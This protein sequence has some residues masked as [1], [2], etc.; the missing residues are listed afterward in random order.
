MDGLEDTDSDL[1][2]P[3]QG[4]GGRMR[5]KKGTEGGGGSVIHKKK[6]KKAKEG[7]EF[8]SH[9]P[10]VSERDSGTALA[11][12][13]QQTMGVMDGNQI[14]PPPPG[15]LPSLWYSRECV[16][17]VF[18]IEKIIGWKT[19][20]VVKLRFKEE[21]DDG[22][23]EIEGATS[24]H[25][26]HH[27]HLDHALAANYS[28]KVIVEH[29]T[30]LRKR[31][32]VSK[33]NPTHCP[34][35]FSY[36][37]K[38]ELARAAKTNETPN[39]KLVPI[40]EEDREEVLLIKWRGRSHLHC[41]W[42][43]K[44]DLEKFDPSNNT[45]RGKIKR[46]LQAQ[47]VAMG[48]DWKK[49][50]EEGRASAIHGH[51]HAPPLPGDA[52][53]AAIA[54]TAKGEED[55]DKRAPVE[56]EEFFPPE[57]VEVERVLACDE[58]DVSPK[59]LAKQRALNRRAESEALLKREAEEA[60]VERRG[61]ATEAN[62]SN[63]NAIKPVAID[64]S[65][66]AASDGKTVD[67]EE[68]APW[69]PEDNV[70]YV[71][72]WK[73]MQYSEITWEY[74][75]DLKRDFVDEVEDFWYRQKAPP[76]E[77]AKMISC[78]PHP[79]MKEFKKLT[80]SPVFGISRRVRP[81]ADL[82]DGKLTGEEEDDKEEEG[83]TSLKLRNYQLEGVNWL[84]W[85]WWN[86]RSCILADEMGLGKTIQ[87]VCF[88]SMLR[89]LPS[90]KVRGPFLVVAPLSLVAQWQSEAAAWAPDM[91]VILYHGSA[92]ARDFL[93]QQEFFYTDQFMAKTNAVKLKRSHITKFHILITTYEVVL[94]DIAILSKIRWKALIVDEAHR[95]KNNKARFFVELATVPRDFC[96]LLTGT[97]LQNSTEELWSLLHFSDP[98]T[99]AS[100]DAFVAKFGQ[101]TDSQQVSDLHSVLKPYLLR[102]V[103]EDVEKALPPKEETI[104]EVTLTPIQKTYYKA[105]YERNTT[106]LFKG[107]KPSN[108]PSLMNVMMELR[109]C[110]NHPFLIRGAEERILAD[111]A[112]AETVSA[113]AKKEG[114]GEEDS[115]NT[116]KDVVPR[117][118]DYMKLTADQLVKSSGKMVLLVKLLPKL[119]AGGHKVLI[120]SQMVRVLDLLEDLLRTKKYR[121]ERLDGS[122]SASSRA[123]AV[124][125]FHRRSCQRFVMLLSTRAGGLGLNLTAADTVVI[126]DSDWNPQNDLQAMARAHRIGQTRA[127]R[128]YRLLTA[129]TYEMHMFHSA[130]MKLGLDRAVLAHQRQH[131]GD[132]DAGGDDSN[133]AG[134][135]SKTK[136]EKELQ[137]KEID[138]LLKKGAYD[139]FRDEDDS[140]AKQF[141]ETDIDQLL[142]RSS[143]KVTYGNT[144]S[145]SSISSGLGS[146][147]KASFVADTGDGDG[148]D[149]DLDDPDFWE[150]AVGLEAPAAD[151]SADGDVLLDGDK[152]RSRKQVQVFDPYAAYAEAEQKKKDKIALKIKAEKE[153][154]ERARKEK[155]QKKL[156]EK[157]RKKKEREEAREAKER[158]QS[159]SSTPPKKAEE[160]DLTASSKDKRSNREGKSKKIKRA[161]RRKAVRK[162]EKEDPILE[163][164]KQGWEMPQRNRATSAALRFGF[165]RFCKIRAEANLTSLPVQDL[166][167]FV[168]SYVYQLGLQAATALLEQIYQ[169]LGRR[170]HIE[171][172]L[173][174]NLYQTLKS[175]LGK[176]GMGQKDREWVVLAMV[177]ALQCHAAVLKKER[178]LR[179]PLTLAEPTFVR[180]LR[181]GAA[182]NALRRFAFLSRL[183]RVMESVLDS[184]LSDLGHEE[185]GKRGCP[186]KDLSTLDVDLKSRHVTIE[187]LSHLLGSRL[188]CRRKISHPAPWW[189]R[190]CDL[191][192]I[193]GTFVHGLGNYEAM[194]TDDRLP[195]GR[196]I[197]RYARGD[198]GTSQAFTCF[199]IAAKAAR[200]VFDD[201]LDEAKAKAQAQAHAAVAAAVAAS[202]LA[203]EGGK[204]LETTKSNAMPSSG[205]LQRVNGAVSPSKQLLNEEP[206]KAPCLGETD[207]DASSDMVTLQ[208]LSRS[209]RG[210]VRAESEKF[211]SRVSQD[212]NRLPDIVSSDHKGDRSG[213][214]E[215]GLPMPDA[216]IL[217]DLLVHLVDDVEKPPGSPRERCMG[218]APQDG[219]KT[220]AV[221][222][223]STGPLPRDG[224]DT[225]RGTVGFQGCHCGTHHRSLD[226]GSDYA[227][228]AASSDLASIASGTD[229]SRYHRG[230]G[231]PILLTRYC[232]SALVYADP[233]TIHNVLVRL[234][235]CGKGLSKYAECAHASSP[236]DKAVPGT[237]PSSSSCSSNVKREQNSAPVAA[238]RALRES[239][240]IIVPPALR[241][242]QTFRTGLSVAVLKFGL[243]S[244]S[245]NEEHGASF[246]CVDAG[247]VR[248][249]LSQ[250]ATPDSFSVTP[251]P[252]FRLSS[253]IAAAGDSTVC[254]EQSVSDY[255]E[256]VLL[257]HCLRLCVLGNDGVSSSDGGDDSV[258]SHCFMYDFL[259]AG[260]VVD[261]PSTFAPRR[262]RR[263]SCLSS[264]PD[265]CTPLSCHSKRAVAYASAILRRVRLMRSIGFFVSGIPFE[266][267]L[268]FLRESSALQ[269][270]LDD[271]PLW[272]CPWIHDLGLLVHA[273]TRGLFALINDVQ[274]HEESLLKE[275][276]SVFHPAAIKRHLR[277]TFLQA[278]NNEAKTVLLSI[279]HLVDEPLPYQLN[280][281]IEHH[282][283]HFPSA[284]AIERRL[285]LIC[286]HLSSHQ[287]IM[288]MND[289]SIMFDT[290]PMFDHGGWPTN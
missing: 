156:E 133:G 50:L 18:V 270:N 70:R 93:V 32:E 258:G 285:A 244:P 38:K 120:F 222:S 35:V 235:E 173:Q 180:S 277:S 20:P 230:P 178:T 104:L 168:R 265:P 129:K 196:K 25:R 108:A 204:E 26:H 22:E 123:A 36:A 193:I 89:T 134:G 110:C 117:S 128:V 100:K 242:N 192:L 248:Y 221:A 239:A 240:T 102:R 46:Y 257:P 52:A 260:G 155:K 76:L 138:E 125:R 209:I 194:K 267:L 58:N 185:L 132:N 259:A 21:G 103:K 243:P 238:D 68:D 152:K 281:W 247:I 1:S 61:D 236:T 149:V 24:K 56:E 114:D 4:S 60:A 288:G 231:V 179:M 79:H 216:E 5:I 64:D 182:L 184:V 41:S 78:R 139:V 233:T 234:D 269:D 197:D 57:C 177:S 215:H 27:K 225:N 66:A 164:I 276:H 254:S 284:N 17:H 142:E 145:S 83:R 48:R 11:L 119:Y 268:S 195:F 113:G 130:S 29:T 136:S 14:D 282:A 188:C 205:D 153:E 7:S 208:R 224:S 212:A 3:G 189:D 30:D 99:F 59:V 286:S 75:I 163:R 74:W 107:S 81:V 92:D 82:G 45:A 278:Q 148:K 261:D 44:R 280:A 8:E 154:K 190:C 186:T 19:R 171:E 223:L 272:W 232:V 53:A 255:C 245:L 115:A 144:T 86:K 249:L 151:A 55:E 256:K 77:E 266:T 283:H 23:A 251:L 140:E 71:I 191:G 137:A 10:H 6:K 275:M 87:S 33:I 227:H 250:S 80:E 198:E 159:G 166:E 51:I 15:V 289:D 206:S 109:K 211:Y 183:N 290:I 98:L 200:K 96:L 214:L 217:D 106:F 237:V 121:Y 39:Y 116:S 162:A 203:E 122:T 287:H 37:A 199:E 34:L 111:A 72:K 207:N 131:E 90:A 63:A 31:M 69:D 213:A 263:G 42:E 65:N 219:M 241:D 88:L 73:G 54:K 143:R 181:N 160:K 202:K 253:L 62:G 158:L 16:M 226:D 28:A 105:I 127:V 169:S 135:K 9:T 165:N 229:A 49:L 91:N 175:Y 264:L 112:A 172:N 228:G 252:L 124:D 150:K 101:L 12:T 210:A 95:L 273:A 13:Q 67:E 141:M 274:Q 176:C 47:E 246:R 146:F 218:T 147:S 220:C 161:E 84:L 40:D 201:A 2:D 170:L 43:R 94:K 174:T 271:L 187:E 262:R 118:I 157:E 279:N 167:V 126:F 85:N 97:P